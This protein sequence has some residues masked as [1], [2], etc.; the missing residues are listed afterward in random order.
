[1]GPDE[2]FL[3]IIA[4]DLNLD[5]ETQVLDLLMENQE[6]LGW[7]LGDIRGISATLNPP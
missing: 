5:Q 7:T 6:A 3:M 4:N 1:L 2:T